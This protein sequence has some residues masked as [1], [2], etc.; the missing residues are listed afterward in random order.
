MFHVVGSVS[1]RPKADLIVVPFFKGKK[2]PDPIVNLPDLKGVISPIIK[3]G[4]FSGKEGATM[5]AYL[6]G[7]NE[8][9]LLFLGLGE[10]KACNLETLRRSFA[11]AMKLCHNKKWPHVSFVLPKLKKFDVAQVTCAVSEG[12]GL[13]F[14]VFEEWK[15]KKE[16]YYVKKITLVGAK[17]AKIPKKTL[18]ILSGVNLTRDLINR[19]ALDVMP[20]TLAAQA[21]KLARN[22]SSV[23][24]T[25]LNK[26]KKK[27]KKK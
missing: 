18:G 10:E 20:Q 27:K 8:K 5:L 25:V 1:K 23:K 3:A 6:T 2:G 11:A 21:K 19:N 7:K 9:R 12:V 16:L 14:Y 24:T 26:K 4:D 22:F 17:D 15:S 13:C